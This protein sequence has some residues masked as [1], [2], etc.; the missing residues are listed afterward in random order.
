MTVR[1]TGHLHCFFSVALGGAA[2]V[3]AAATQYLADAPRPH[4]ALLLARISAQASSRLPI[5]NSGVGID[6]LRGP[7]GIVEGHLQ[8]WKASSTRPSAFCAVFAARIRFMLLH[9]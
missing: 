5:P 4:E 7:G 1:L 6:K 2:T 3:S 9:I 8:L